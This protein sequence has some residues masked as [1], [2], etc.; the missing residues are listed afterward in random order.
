MAG[1]YQFDRFLLSFGRHAFHLF[2]ENLHGFSSTFRGRFLSV[3]VVGTIEN[4]GVLDLPNQ[5]V[6][7]VVDHD[8]CFFFIKVR[9]DQRLDGSLREFFH[10]DWFGALC[11]CLLSA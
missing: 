9:G 8:P 4:R 5:N 10:R 7:H 6:C 2:D 1:S 11:Q 3:I